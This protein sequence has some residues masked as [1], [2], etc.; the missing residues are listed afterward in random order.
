MVS[1]SMAEEQGSNKICTFI[2]YLPAIS[3]TSVY[4]ASLDRD[5]KI[6]R[7]GGMICLLIRI[8]E[9]F[10]FCISLDSFY[11]LYMWV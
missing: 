6:T 1:R 4:I 5:K 10:T 8:E 2:A 9:K 3:S 11:Y 7:R